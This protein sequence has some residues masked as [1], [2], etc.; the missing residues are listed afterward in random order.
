MRLSKYRLFHDRLDDGRL[1]TRCRNLFLQEFVAIPSPAIQQGCSNRLSK[2]EE[3]RH[4]QEKASV[5]RQVLTIFLCNGRKIYKI[6]L[7]NNPSVSMAKETRIRPDDAISA[8]N[9]GKLNFPWP[10][11]NLNFLPR[12]RMLN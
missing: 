5:S 1:V 8:Y 11:E 4:T 9:G 10:M 6:S 3:I 2:D 12:M 7:K